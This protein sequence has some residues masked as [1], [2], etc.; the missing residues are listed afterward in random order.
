MSLSVMLP[1]SSKVNTHKL[2]D[3]K[4]IH[5]IPLNVALQVHPVCAILASIWASRSY[6]VVY[7]MQGR[8]A[9]YFPTISET[10]VEDFGIKLQSRT[11]TG[12]SLMCIF[13]DLWTAMHC[14]Q[15]SDNSV[16]L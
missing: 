3:G 1:A 10:E 4:E 2:C 14:A 12:V 16:P 15:F 11:F 6:F 8:W 5:T 9:N 7:V 13:P